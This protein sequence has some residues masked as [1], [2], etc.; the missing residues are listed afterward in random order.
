VDQGADPLATSDATFA[1]AG[2]ELDHLGAVIHGAETCKLG[3]AVHGAK[4]RVHFLKSFQK[5]RICEILLK[6]DKKTKKKSVVGCRVSGGGPFNC[7]VGA[8]IL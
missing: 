7:L 8:P 5:R 6:K 1:H 4:V 3:A 2:Q